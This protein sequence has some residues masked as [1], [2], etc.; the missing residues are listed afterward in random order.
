MQIALRSAPT[1]MSARSHEREKAVAFK[2]IDIAEAAIFEMRDDLFRIVV[3]LDDAV[4]GAIT[5]GAGLEHRVF[6]GTGNLLTCGVL[7]DDHDAPTGS[8]RLSHGIE[9]CGNFIGRYV[10]EK[11]AEAVSV[12]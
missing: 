10:R 6:G 12:Q 1:I 9:E 5:K 7:I 3:H 8:H 2:Q 4:A 11:E